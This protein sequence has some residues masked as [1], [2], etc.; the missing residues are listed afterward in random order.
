MQLAIGISFECEGFAASRLVHD[1]ETNAENV[2]EYLSD[3]FGLDFDQILLV[4]TDDEGD[5][6]VVKHWQSGEDF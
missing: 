5:P 6:L 2:A 4:D 1:L 3:E